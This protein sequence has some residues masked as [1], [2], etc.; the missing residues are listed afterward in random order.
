MTP[1]RRETLIVGLVTIAA[2][3]VRFWGSGRL[4]LSHFD[5]GIYAD[6]G[7]WS[8]GKG[9]LTDLNPGVIP[10]APAGWP[11]VVGL[12]YIAFGASD[13]AAI[14][15]AQL[16][17]VATI[18][19]VGWLARR[20]FGPGAGA[21]A[22]ALAAGSGSQVA[23]SRMAM[24]DAP[25]LL[26]WLLAL[27]LGGRFLERPGAGRAILFGLAVGLAQQFKYNGWLAG[28]AIAGT[29]GL[30]LIAGIRPRRTSLRVLLLGTIAVMAASAV[31]WPWY[32]F[33]EANGGYAGLLRHQRSYLGGWRAWWPGLRAQVDM[34]SAL[35]GGPA[36]G[37]IAGL[38]AGA[39]AAWAIGVP[40]RFVAAILSAIGLAV[41][42]SSPF[43][44]AVAALPGLLRDDRPAARS[45]GVAL[46][47][48]VALTP[49]YHPYAR[50]WLPIHGL[51]WLIVGGGMAEAVGSR[52]FGRGRLIVV[53]AAITLA[54]AA[55]RS[56]PLPGLL[57]PTDSLERIAEAIGDALPRHVRAIRAY[58]RPPL[59]RDLQRI[60]QR[61][62]VGR[63]DGLM[64]FERVEANDIWHVV[65]DYLL[66][67][68][69]QPTAVELPIWEKWEVVARLEETPSPAALLDVDPSAS[70]PRSFGVWLLR[71]RPP[72]TTP[73]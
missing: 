7:T 4:G 6:A 29:V 30:D 12:S 52:S 32:R 28:A 15:A 5:E 43:F 72:G 1:A 40:R 54:F 49:F 55:T 57:G 45:L 3:A 71:P 36:W 53:V 73:R 50:L 59:L 42:P 11:I 56:R 46:V 66:T 18:P 9:G 22:S 27:G 58:A 69:G 35:S 41:A 34:A 13:A 63:L 19:L 44:L 65:D 61:P 23:F 26:L 25:F 60:K 64:A 37:A 17:G 67:T 70:R 14:F 31:V 33:V 20:T 21:A 47:L 62:T 68:A 16:A 48:M 51:S 24:T 38:S 10:Y 8:L 39:S 2:A